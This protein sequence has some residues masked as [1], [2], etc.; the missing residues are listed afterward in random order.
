MAASDKIFALLD[1]PEPKEKTG[2]LVGGPL[3]IQAREVRFSYEEDR[4]I[5][6]GV[7][8]EFPAGSFT[9]LV[10]TSGCGKSTIAGILMGRNQNYQGSIRINGQ[11]LSE[12]SEKSL[13]EKITLVSHN[14]YLFKGTVKENLKMGKPD[15]SDGEMNQVLE[16][17]NLSGFLNAQEGLDTQ[18]LEK[19]SNFSGGQCQRLALARAL[20]HDSPIYIFDEATSNIDMESEEMIM[21]VIHRLAETKTV[22]L[23]S[24]RLANVEGSDCI[25]MLKDGMVAQHGTHHELMA[26]GGPY[27]ELY[28]YQRELEMYSQKAS[29][30][31]Q[32]AAALKFETGTGEVTV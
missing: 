4:Q 31:T 23:I 6:K 10:G 19:G 7:S 11:E 21:E 28:Q 1:L 22:I 25:Y 5:L 3:S 17:V 26:Q 9:S 16:K 18:L 30:G 27:R 29:R 13:M 8:L 24:H 2:V 14:S 12:I 32:G 20:L 15:A